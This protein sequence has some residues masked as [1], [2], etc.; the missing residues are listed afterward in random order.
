VVVVTGYPHK[1]AALLI[2]LLLKIKMRCCYSL[3]PTVKLSTRCLLLLSSPEP[4][5]PDWSFAKPNP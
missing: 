1:K 5:L 2:A 3:N 4:P